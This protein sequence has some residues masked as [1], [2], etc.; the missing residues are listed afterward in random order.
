M[1]SMII[2]YKN[3]ELEPDRS[4]WILTQ[5]WDKINPKDKTVSYGQIDQIYPTTLESALKSIQHRLLKNKQAT[6]ELGT[7]IEELKAIDREFVQD[8]KIL[9]NE[10]WIK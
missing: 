3:F 6:V 8:I 1:K 10:S 2:K 7:F 9:L 5:Y 4:C